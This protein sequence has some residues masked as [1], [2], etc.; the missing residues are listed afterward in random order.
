[1]RHLTAAAG[2]LA[3]LVACGCG[4]SSPSAPAP[5]EPFNQTLTGTVSSFGF[6]QHP[7][8]AARAGNM[9]LTLTWQTTADL[10]LYLTSSTCNQYP[11]GS[12]QIL[13]A[14]D[15]AVGSSEVITR[16]VTSG[17]SFKFWIDNFSFNPQNYSVQIQI[18]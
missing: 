6:T 17:E 11:N 8:S 12:C 16:T 10:D 5:P 7:L 9:T 1:M 4:K 14:S 15:R 13:A 18:Q 3:L 2:I